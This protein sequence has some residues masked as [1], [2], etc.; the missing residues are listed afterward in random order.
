MTPW[1]KRIYAFLIPLVAGSYFVCATLFA[2]KITPMPGGTAYGTI[3]FAPVPEC[4]H[5]AED[6]VRVF[7]QRPLPDYEYQYIMHKLQ[8]CSAKHRNEVKKVDG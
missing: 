1:H 3:T 6:L 2:G 8:A 5:M 4:Q 7:P